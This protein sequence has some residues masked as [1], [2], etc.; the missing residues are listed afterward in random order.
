MCCYCCYDVPISP[1]QGFNLLLAQST[2]SL[3]NKREQEK[4]NNSQQ[5]VCVSESWSPTL[6]VHDVQLAVQI[7]E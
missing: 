6:P 5:A 4:H 2:I 3:V 1:T 7:L